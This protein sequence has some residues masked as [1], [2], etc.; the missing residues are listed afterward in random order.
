MTSDDPRPP[1]R[2]RLSAALG[3][4]ALKGLLWQVLV[5]GIAVAV[6]AFLWSNT[7]TNLS[8]RRITTGF[9]F[10][11]RE[12]GM[13]IAESL[14]AY[15]PRD[16][17]LWAFV[18]G[19]AN[20]LR[21]AVI[22]IVLAS[23]LGTLIGI[24]RLSSNWLLSR[25]AAVYVETLRDI[26]LLL[27]LLFWYV[28]MQALPAARSAFRPVEG[29][30]LSNRGLIL[31]A[32]PL[33]PPQ[34]WVLGAGALGLAAFYLVRRWQVAQQ[35]RD[36]KPRLAWPFAVGL[37]IGLPV[38]VSVLLGVSWTIEW[39][40]LRGFNF[41]GGLTLAPEYFALLIA[42]VTYTSAFIAEIVR[43]GIQSVPRGQWDAANALGLRRSFMLRQIILPQA[44]RVIVPPMTSQYLNLTKNSSLA[45]AIGYQDVVSIANTTLNQTGQ[46][47]EAIA[48]I[49]AV[50]LTISLA[51]SFFMNWYN[52]RIALVER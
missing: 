34:L 39:P 1:P 46:A 18:V 12:A 30:F 50:F 3:P 51:I 4:N 47:I 20:T 14:L 19:I 7:V 27:Q 11:G 37:I 15:N 31:P 40:A 44:L 5:V 13:P 48:L 26:P 41:V 36:G 24:S 45:V 32:I 33:G 25:M 23:I 29:V 35:M 43:S 10:L 49:M 28:L 17:Y 42:L 52:S 9:A 21:V 22:G 8:A 38:L 2:R 6:I 16:T